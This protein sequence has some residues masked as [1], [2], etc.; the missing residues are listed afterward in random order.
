MD[1]DAPPQQ[2][3][4]NARNFF[5]SKQRGTETIK[6]LTAG[7]TKGVGFGTAAAAKEIAELRETTKA[8][9]EET[10]AQAMEDKMRGHDQDKG[11]KQALA[12]RQLRNDNAANKKEIK[13]SP[14]QSPSSPSRSRS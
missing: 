14:V 11:G 9:I 13:N 4:A 5:E 12:M 6:R 3:Y 7:A 1:R 8:A 10:L 2:T